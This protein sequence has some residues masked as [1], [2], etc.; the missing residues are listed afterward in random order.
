MVGERCVGR[1]RGPRQRYHHFANARSQRNAKVEFI[2]YSR[3]RTNRFLSSGFVLHFVLTYMP[4]GDL[5]DRMEDEGK[6]PLSR[7]RLYMAEAR[8]APRPRPSPRPSPSLAARS[9][10][11]RSRPWILSGCGR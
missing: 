7:V 5:Y 8:R 10:V 1:L 11:G 6:L 9:V 2:R 3:K 4:G